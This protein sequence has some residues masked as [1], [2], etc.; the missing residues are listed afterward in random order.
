MK[1]G[2][3][4]DRRVGLLLAGVVFITF[5]SLGVTVALP[6]SDPTVRAE[7]GARKLNETELRGMTIYRN[8]GC[9]YCHTQTVRNT[10]ID[11]PFGDALEPAVYADQSPALLGG[12]R[13]GPDLTHVGARYA[14][15]ETLIDLLRMPR[16]DGR[17]SSMPSYAY[18]SA[19]DLNSLAAYLLALK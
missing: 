7:K 4:A 12:E 10:P 16:A 14:D 11:E 8:E 3:R 2:M 5:V 18:L 6:A 1:T 15:A 17:T 19:N 13:V 9:W